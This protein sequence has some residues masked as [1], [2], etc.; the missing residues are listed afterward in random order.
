MR[1]SNIPHY[2]NLSGQDFVRLA[3]NYPGYYFRR[4]RGIRYAEKTV[5]DYR[6]ILDLL[7]EGI[8]REL[9]LIQAREK[10]HVVMLRSVLEPGMTVL[11]IGANI[12]YYSVMMGRLVGNTG[13][14]YALEP[15]TSNFHLLN[16]NLGLNDMNGVVET[17]NVGVADK[18]GEQDFFQS[19]RS[20]WHTFYPKVHSGADTESLV[21]SSSV[22][23]PVVTMPDFLRGR[24]RIDLIRMD[25]EGFEV[26][27]LTG[28]LPLLAD[29]AFRPT[30]LFEVHRP[31]YD[32]QE[33][34]MRVVL[35]ALFEAGYVVATLASNQH[36]DGGAQV[37]ERRGYE[38]QQVIKTDF[39]RR[40]LYM[41]VSPADA[42]ELLCDTNYVRAALLTRAG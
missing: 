25:V 30:I 20:N 35:R 33:H 18:T 1:L 3:V 24:R 16:V 38:P 8:S 28:L 37:F 10:E 6:M 42:I 22:K 5:H 17:F 29:R 26:E 27:I 13:K 7:D 2:L 21:G 31:R 11:D 41:G 40:G 23:V 19:G 36:T 4:A 12:G 14:V 32:D 15:A 34:N 9:W 39:Q